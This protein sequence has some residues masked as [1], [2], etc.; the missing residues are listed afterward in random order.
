[1]DVLT[2]RHSLDQLSGAAS[3]RGNL[4]ETQTAWEAVEKTVKDQLDNSSDD[5]SRKAVL[6]TLF[7]TDDGILAILESSLSQQGE[8]LAAQS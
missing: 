2:L 8:K 7:S 5:D 1:M 6:R 4:T 3:Q